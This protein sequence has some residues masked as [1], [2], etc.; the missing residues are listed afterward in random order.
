MKDKGYF[1]KKKNINKKRPQD[2]KKNNPSVYHYKLGNRKIKLTVQ[3]QEE[4]KEVSLTSA[5]FYYSC[6]FCKKDFDQETQ[7]CPD[8]TR[9]LAKINLRKCQQ[10]GA[11]NPPAKESCWVCNAAFPKLEVATTKE[12]KTVLVL[13]ADGMVYKSTDESLSPDLKKLFSDLLSSKFS[14]QALE[15]W[16]KRTGLKDAYKKESIKEELGYLKQQ[17]QQQ[18]IVFLL[19]VIGA[20]VAIILLI[21]VFWSIFSG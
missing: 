15:A 9:P 7:V 1:F 10:C 4:C 16:A 8:C 20:I 21:R 6:V 14:K 13:E 17:H 12:M 2:Q 18:D 11:K 19:I 5:V 3:K